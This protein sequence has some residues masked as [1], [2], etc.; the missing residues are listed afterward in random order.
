[1]LPEVLQHAGHVLQWAAA[2]HQLVQRQLARRVEIE[3]LRDVDVRVDTAVRAPGQ[4]PLLDEAVERHLD[5]RP[6]V[7]HAKDHRPTT[8]AQ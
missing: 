8:A 4:D 3:D 5:H 6:C 7:G 1:L 2:G